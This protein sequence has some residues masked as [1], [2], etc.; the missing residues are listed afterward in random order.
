MIKSLEY[1]KADTE[2]TKL[3]LQTMS[4]LDMRYNL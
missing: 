2:L 4:L 3:L 1:F